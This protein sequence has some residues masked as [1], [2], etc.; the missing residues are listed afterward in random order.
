MSDKKYLWEVEVT[1]VEW[2]TVNLADWTSRTLT[3][4]QLEYMLTDMPLDLTGQRDLMTKH[5]V[6]DMVSVLEKHD[7]M[8]RDIT[9]I[10]EVL[11]DSYNQNYFAA[12]AKAFGTANEKFSNSECVWHIRIS[13]IMRVL[14]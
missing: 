2:N 14:S 8:K 11:V 3:N 13:D 1:S 10:V 6:L 5:A 12:I 9:H 4:T 7:V